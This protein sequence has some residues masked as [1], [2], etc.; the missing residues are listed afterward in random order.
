MPGTHIEVDEYVGLVVMTELEPLVKGSASHDRDKQHGKG[1]Q[2]R[3]ELP[4]GRAC[5]LCSLLTWPCPEERR[6]SARPL[7][8]HRCGPVTLPVLMRG[9]GADPRNR[10][11]KKGPR[12]KNRSTQKTKSESVRVSGARPVLAC[13]AGFF[14]FWCC[15]PGLVLSCSCAGFFLLRCCSLGSVFPCSFLRS[16][17]PRGCS[18]FLVRLRLV[19]APGFLL[20]FLSLPGGGRYV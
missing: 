7:K 6:S 15:S 10:A 17:P 13:C 14:V 18:W 12:V 11:K 9:T 1:E 16:W 3:R 19:L 8:D 20:C 2:V 4:L 5:T